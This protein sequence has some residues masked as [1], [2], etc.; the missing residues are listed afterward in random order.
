M[1]ESFSNIIAGANGL[2]NNTTAE[3]LGA[4]SLFFFF[5]RI[6]FYLHKSNAVLVK[7][8]AI[9]FLVLC[10]TC[11]DP[12]RATNIGSVISNLYLGAF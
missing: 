2:V 8:E 1:R 9:S 4:E 12:L 6:D 3:E 7:K 10:I 5:I 11:Q